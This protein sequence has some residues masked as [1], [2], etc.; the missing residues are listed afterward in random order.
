MSMAEERS[1]REYNI[2]EARPDTE[3]TFTLP[4]DPNPPGILLM[5]PRRDYSVVVDVP[6]DVPRL[7][8]HDSSVL[9]RYDG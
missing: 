6:P 5:C 9:V 3:R 4:G 7:C 2:D 1:T 8:P